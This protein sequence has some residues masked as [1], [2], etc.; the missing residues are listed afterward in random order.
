MVVHVAWP[1]S[2]TMTLQPKEGQN[3]K[4]VACDLDQIFDSRNLQDLVEALIDKEEVLFDDTIA[5]AKLYDFPAFGA[6]R[7]PPPALESLCA[8]L[9][10]HVQTALSPLSDVPAIMVLERQALVC[11]RVLVA[12]ERHIYSKTN[13]QRALASLKKGVNEVEEEGAEA[14]GGE[15]AAGPA[16]TAPSEPPTGNSILVE[17][18][19][20]TGLSVVFSLLRHSW[21]QLSWQR[22]LEQQLKLSGM[23]ALTGTA[24]TV[25]LP[26]EVLRSVLEALKGIPP[27]SLSNV[28]TLTEL[29]RSCL[30]QSSEFLTWSLSPASQVDGEGKRLACEIFLTLT[31]QQGS[32]NSLLDWVEKML[33][34]LVAY[35][36]EEEEEGR[37]EGDAASA[38]AL[39]SFSPEFCATV[40]EEI[41]KRTVSLFRKRGREGGGENQIESGKLLIE[42]VFAR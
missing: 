10:E 37:G 6:S 42:A 38:A 4:W 21:M 32:L 9:S 29:S 30:E 35:R 12:C 33:T 5:F 25:S 14:G 28:K 16:V 20:R 17:V 40:V 13:V 18:G 26:N 8:K 7:L 41:N 1:V 34:C 2:D 31:L 19:V 22:K 36:D 15:A 23:A 11:R 3:L 24:P 39:P 27:L